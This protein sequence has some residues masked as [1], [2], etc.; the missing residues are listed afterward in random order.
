MITTILTALLIAATASATAQTP[1]SAPARDP[2]TAARLAKEGQD[3]YRQGK[4]GEALITYE[5]AVD[6][7]AEGGELFYQMG[8]CY[9]TVRDDPDKARQYM[10]RAVPFLEK[11]TA[12]T[13]QTSITPYYYLAAA[14]ANELGDAAKGKAVAQRGVTLVGKGSY[15]NVKDGET[16]F[17]IGRLYSLA[18]DNDKALAWYEKAAAAFDTGKV[19]NIQYLITCHEQIASVALQKGDY[20]KSILSLKRLMELDPSREQERLS[21]GMI[22][23]KAGKYQDAIQVLNGFVSDDLGSEANYIVRVLTRYTGFG[24]PAIPAATTKLSDE[25]LAE[26]TRKS[27]ARLS[28]LRQKDDEKAVADTPEEVPYEWRTTSKGKKVKVPLKPALPPPDWQPKDPNNPTAAEYA[29][30]KGD[31]IAPPLKT[32]PTSPERLAAE[33]EFFTLLTED[34]RRGHLLRE[35]AVINGFAS[36]IFR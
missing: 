24:S 23:I 27:A 31:I 19:T 21:A 12:D 26:E 25:A 29:Y 10:T 7:G 6:A 11:I 17:Q 13:S 8:Y 9:K 30:M 4:L 33:K 5:K 2:A 35:N 20:E 14:Y 22:M 36:L 16:L 18:G 15:T 32:I 28:E 3:L 1:E 34:L